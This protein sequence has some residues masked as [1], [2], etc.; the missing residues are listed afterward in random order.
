MYEE[1]P[2]FPNAKRQI[3]YIKTLYVFFIYINYSLYHRMF[4]AALYF[5]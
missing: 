1:I 2:E 4:H 3:Y 5:I